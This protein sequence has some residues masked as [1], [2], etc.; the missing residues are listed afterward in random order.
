MSKSEVYSWR[1]SP[2]LKSAL[3]QAARSEQTTVS[4]LLDSIVVGWLET[5]ESNGDEKSIQRR[6]HQTA[7]RTLGKIR[8]GDPRRAERA[9]D[10]VRKRLTKRR[11]R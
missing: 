6:L 10:L 5:T 2:E 4:K 3:E 11:E 7:S 8:G 9:R 1:V